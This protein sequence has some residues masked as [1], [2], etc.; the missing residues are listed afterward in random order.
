MAEMKNNKNSKE[1]KRD[2]DLAATRKTEDAIFSFL[3]KIGKKDL[4]TRE[5]EVELTRRIERGERRLAEAM[6]SQ[7]RRGCEREIKAARMEI[8]RARAELIEANQRLVVMI[9][10]RYVNRGL[11]FLD[12]IQEGNIGLMRAV[13]KFDYRRGYKFSTYATWWVRQAIAR[14]VS[15]LGRSIRLPVHMSESCNKVVRTSR[16]LTPRLGREPTESEIAARAEIPLEQVRKA[17]DVVKEPV[18]LDTPIGE[19]GDASIGD[20]V[21][22]RGALTPEEAT[23]GNNVVDKIHE[24]L[25]TLTPREEAMIRMRYGIGFKQEHTLEEIGRMHKVTRERIRQIEEKALKKLRHPVRSRLL[26]E[27]F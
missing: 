23:H 10:K 24:I 13:E 3:S 7:G 9:A 19:D 20:M 17:L 25:K 15:D 16:Y 14:S 4:L 12:L 26:E 27:L 5:G 18:S 6:E 2:E 22:D 8:D 1:L 21:R 11:Q